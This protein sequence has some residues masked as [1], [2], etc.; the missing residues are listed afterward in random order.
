LQYG[1]RHAAYNLKKLRGKQIVGRI[2]QTRRYQPWRP[3]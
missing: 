1:P 3:A 2:G